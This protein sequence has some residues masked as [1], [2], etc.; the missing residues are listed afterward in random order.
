M[1]FLRAAGSGFKNK[2]F[3]TVTF[4]SGAFSLNYRFRW[5]SSI[6]DS[7]TAGC[8]R[9]PSR[10]YHDMQIRYDVGE[11][12]KFGLYFGVNNMFESSRRYSPTNPVTSRAR[13]HRPAPTTPSAA[14]S[15][16]A[17]T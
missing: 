6:V 14:C 13:R 3:G 10:S 16:R 7:S 15:T 5:Y 12:R 1:L 17:S 8:D 11:D 2:V 9:V 4:A